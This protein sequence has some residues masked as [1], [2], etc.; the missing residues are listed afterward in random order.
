MSQPMKVREEFAL[1]NNMCGC[2]LWNAKGE[3]IPDFEMLISLLRLPMVPATAED[4]WFCSPVS[5]GVTYQCGSCG[6][7]LLRSFGGSPVWRVQVRYLC[8]SILRSISPGDSQPMTDDNR[9][10]SSL[11]FLPNTRLLNRELSWSP[12]GRPG[13]S[14]N[15]TAAYPSF[16]LASTDVRPASGSAG[17]S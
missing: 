10:I 7:T 16:L 4:S 14:H 17:P 9:D 12:L 1:P 13:H 6:H 15:S 11:T 3:R 2:T 5:W 8:C